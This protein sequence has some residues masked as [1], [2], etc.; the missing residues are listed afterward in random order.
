M[1]GTIRGVRSRPG[2][3][4]VPIDSSRQVDI[5]LVVPSDVTLS[6]VSLSFTE[7]T[8]APNHV[9]SVLAPSLGVSAH[10][11]GDLEDTLPF[12]EG[13]NWVDPAAGSIQRSGLGRISWGTAT[14][15]GELR[16]VPANQE[17][18]VHSPNIIDVPPET[19]AEFQPSPTAESAGTS[20]AAQ[21]AEPAESTP[22]VESVDL[23]RARDHTFPP[24]FSGVM[25]LEDT[26]HMSLEQQ[27]VQRH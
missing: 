5:R 8:A 2:R 25:G 6:N 18:L 16:D 13:Q 21:S 26:A 7:R 27:I 20:Q 22:F 1:S 23:G 10:G 14:I 12:Y 4:P 3:S 11:L 9:D 19:Q 15:D 24:T 17:V